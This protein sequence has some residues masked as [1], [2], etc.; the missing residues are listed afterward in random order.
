MSG[1]PGGSTPSL[2]H[3]A[4][5]PPPPVTKPATTRPTVNL[6]LGEDERLDDI[7]RHLKRV[8]HPLGRSKGEI[9]RAFFTLIDDAM[10]YRM[11]GV[12]PPDDVNT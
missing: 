11:L 12:Q 8:G 6:T 10:F 1:V 4:L 5:S 2:V 7:K 3:A 9:V